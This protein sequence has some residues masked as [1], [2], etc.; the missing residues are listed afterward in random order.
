MAD[1]VLI[2]SQTAALAHA[3]P[4][5]R[6]SHQDT[7]AANRAQVEKGRPVPE[8]RPVLTL[9]QR[10]T[11]LETKLA[12]LLSQPPAAPAALPAADSKDAQK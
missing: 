7:L 12:G 11:L 6:Q 3:S 8:Y 4:D 2:P 1:T 9:E 5:A 10:V